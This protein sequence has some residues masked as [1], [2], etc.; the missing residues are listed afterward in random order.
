M[1]KLDMWLDAAR[2]HQAE[3]KEL[4][5]V[6]NIEMYEYFGKPVKITHANV[7]RGGVECTV[8]S[9]MGDILT[10]D[11]SELSLRK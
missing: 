1:S 2:A 6:L 9:R 7:Y 4:P 10:I 8:E 11:A 3:A 5:I